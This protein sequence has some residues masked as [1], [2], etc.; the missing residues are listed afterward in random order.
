MIYS[1]SGKKFPIDTQV[2]HNDLDGMKVLKIFIYLNNVS[3]FNFGP[4]QFIEDSN[5]FC[6]K[7]KKKLNNWKFRLLNKNKDKT[8]KNKKIISFLGKVGD[9]LFLNTANYHRGLMPKN[10]NRMILILSFIC[11]NELITN[12]NF[13]VKKNVKF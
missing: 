4:I 3:N 9:C 11:H 5:I 1:F 13:K 7:Y 8:F 6:E 10:K 12:N 2:F